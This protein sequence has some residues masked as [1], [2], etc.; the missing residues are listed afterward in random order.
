[1]DPTQSSSLVLAIASAVLAVVVWVV[2]EKRFRSMAAQAA[3]QNATVTVCVSETGLTF[4]ED[5]QEYPYEQLQ[6]IRLPEMR[7]LVFSTQ[8]VGLPDRLFSERVL[9]LWETVLAGQK[10]DA[11]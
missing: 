6:C 8:L 7:I 5:T 3:E 1:M 9:Q 11:V 2:P 4:G 10:G